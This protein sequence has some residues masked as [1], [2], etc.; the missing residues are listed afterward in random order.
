LE[1]PLM[2]VILQQMTYYQFIQLIQTTK[3]LQLD[4]YIS[5]CGGW[6]S[7]SQF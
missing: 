2:H 7:T 6:D 4:I 3:L 5:W 1:G